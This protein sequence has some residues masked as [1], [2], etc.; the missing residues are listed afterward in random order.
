MNQSTE[1][2]NVEKIYKTYKTISR[3]WLGNCLPIV[4]NIMRTWVKIK[5]R[6]WKTMK[7]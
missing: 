1:T 7:V 2:L 6:Q 3:Y 5:I 4:E